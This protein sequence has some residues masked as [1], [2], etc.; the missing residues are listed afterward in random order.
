MLLYGKT[1][2]ALLFVMMLANS[3]IKKTLRERLHDVKII[4]QLLIM[5]LGLILYVVIK[6]RGF[7]KNI[8]VSRGERAISASPLAQLT[9]EKHSGFTDVCY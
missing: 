7:E 4:K 8:Y 6:H 3:S 9:M 1:T 5:T 2:I